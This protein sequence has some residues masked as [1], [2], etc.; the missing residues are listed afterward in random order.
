MRAPIIGLSPLGGR[1]RG[2]REGEGGGEARERGPPQAGTAI[3]D[4]NAAGA[5][6]SKPLESL[7][8]GGAEK[9]STVAGSGGGGVGEVGGG[10]AWRAW[11]RLPCPLPRKVG[12][13]GSRPGRRK[14]RSRAWA[15]GGRGV[16]PDFETHAHEFAT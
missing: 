6:A 1:W 15:G 2:Y 3:L 9:K 11:L 7:C 5:A 10:G 14:R 12:G 4:K 8:G 13:W 16:T